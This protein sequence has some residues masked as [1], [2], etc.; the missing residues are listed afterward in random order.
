MDKL[1]TLNALH[2]QQVK[3]R[4]LSGAH[5][6]AKQ[7]MAILDAEAARGPRGKNYRKPV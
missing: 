4:D 5:E 3:A 1:N 7:I 2:T 6:T